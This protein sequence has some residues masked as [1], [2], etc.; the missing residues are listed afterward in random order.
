MDFNR[1]ANERF[2]GS[3]LRLLVSTMDYR[4]WTMDYYNLSTIFAVSAIN[5]FNVAKVA[6]SF[7]RIG[8]DTRMVA[9]FTRLPRS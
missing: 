2:A 5:D 3:G 7:S 1:Q 6:P 9:P 4:P 8:I